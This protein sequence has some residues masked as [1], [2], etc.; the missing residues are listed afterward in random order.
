MFQLFVAPRKKKKPHGVCVCLSLLWTSA[1][2]TNAEQYGV[3]SLQSSLTPPAPFSF[4]RFFPDLPLL[5]LLRFPPRCSFRGAGLTTPQTTSVSM[6]TMKE[7]VSV[8]CERSGAMQV[9]QNLATLTQSLV[10][11]LGLLCVHSL[12]DA[13]HRAL[14][15]L[16]H[17]MKVEPFLSVRPH[18]HPL[19]RLGSATYNRTNATSKYKKKTT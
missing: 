19:I 11:R 9:G 8:A 1:E 7:L 18:L 2:Q 15:R 14:H 17:Q 16:Q 5:L 12:A 3:C 13:N 6:K 4:Y 10:I